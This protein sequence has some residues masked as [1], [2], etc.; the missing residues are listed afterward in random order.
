M[1]EDKKITNISLSSKKCFSIDGDGTRLLY[2]DTSDMNVI[3]RLEE[4]YSSLSDLADE[5][6]KNLA[7]M[8]ED[9]EEE[10]SLGSFAEALKSIDKKMREKVDYIFDSNVSEVCAPK[11]NM[12]DPVNGVFRFQHII[13]VLSELYAKDIADG[14]KKMQANVAKHT[15]KYT[16]PTQ[17]KRKK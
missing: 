6:V 1:V 14:F 16:K 8:P 5:A 12:Y 9:G 13:E 2:L 11:G 15:A 7:S 3:V 4:V 10:N 17:T